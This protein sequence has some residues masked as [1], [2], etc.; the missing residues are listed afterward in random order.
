MK[1]GLLQVSEGHRD[2]NYTLAFRS[3]SHLYMKVYEYSIM[4]CLLASDLACQLSLDLDQGLGVWVLVNRV[5][6]V[7]G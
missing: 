3:L 4:S 5:D 7:V 6:D 1:L 2:N